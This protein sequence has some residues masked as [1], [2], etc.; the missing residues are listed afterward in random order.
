[1]AFIEELKSLCEKTQAAIDDFP[2]IYG[3][4]KKEIT[5]NLVKISEDVS[6]DDIK[7]CP[8][9]LFLRDFAYIHKSLETK[10][11]SVVNVYKKDLKVLIDKYKSDE[12]SRLLLLDK[13][14]A[15]ESRAKGKFKQEVIS[16]KAN[17]V[18]LAGSKK[19]D[20][21]EASLP[22]K[23]RDTAKAV[24]KPRA[25]KKAEPKENM[26][27]PKEII[28]ETA[29][30]IV[31]SEI[32]A[33]RSETENALESAIL[34][35]SSRDLELTMSEPAYFR[36]TLE[37][38]MLAEIILMPGSCIFLPMSLVHGAEGSKGVIEYII[39][40]GMKKNMIFTSSTTEDFDIDA[41]QIAYERRWNT[42][43][44]K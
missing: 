1:M 16:L 41:M 19:P 10:Y 33:E 9:L 3:E 12:K 22:K 38:G 37:N 42:K 26:E 24:A 23:S 13:L 21:Q 44:F 28:E 27:E 15:E 31:E 39:E 11:K 8:Q 43:L 7:R 40:K 6:F 18:E 20:K 17:L 25:R 2:A 36:G 32:L 30:D 14:G 29:R 5:Q 34:N 35:A 4:T